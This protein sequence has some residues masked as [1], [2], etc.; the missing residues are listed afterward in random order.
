MRI[1]TLLCFLVGVTSFGYQFNVRPWTATTKP[2]LRASKYDE[3]NDERFGR[4]AAWN[5]LFSRGVEYVGR[6]SESAFYPLKF[7]ISP[8]SSD[9]SRES[10]VKSGSSGVESGK[11]PRVMN[12]ALLPSFSQGPLFPTSREFL[13][14]YEM[15]FRGLMNEAEKCDGLLGHCFISK[16]DEVA[17]VGSLCRIIESKKLADGKGFFI[18]EAQQRFRVLKMYQRTPYIRAEVE[19]LTDEELLLEPTQQAAAATESQAIAEAVYVCLKQYLRINRASTDVFEEEDEDDEDDDEDDDSGA[20]GVVVVMGDEG[21]QLSEE[22]TETGWYIGLNGDGPVLRSDGNGRTIGD[23]REEDDEDEEDEDDDD[24]DDDTDY[25]NLTAAI[26]D[27]K[28]LPANRAQTTPPAE[29]L[30][31]YS[32]FSFAVTNLLHKDVDVLQQLMQH[33]S[34]LNRLRGLRAI[35]ADAVEELSDALIDEGILV[36]DDLEA[37]A[38][39]SRDAHDDDSSLLPEP[40]SDGLTLDRELDNELLGRMGLSFDMFVSESRFDE[41]LGKMVVSTATLGKQDVG[42][43]RGTQIDEFDDPAAFQ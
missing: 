17:A 28:P 33:S 15:R 25:L 3:L 11:L 24:D 14:I 5:A 35:L 18:I 36:T 23:E 6:E 38:A 2:K 34:I 37:I 1:W 13:F 43:G 27:S 21:V 4:K 22:R 29:L 42:K 39:M 8:E 31:R 9:K 7:P 32:S 20:E 10:D 16:E 12:L 40:G 30:A 26:R 41:R 19:L